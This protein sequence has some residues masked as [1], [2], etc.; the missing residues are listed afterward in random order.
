VDATHLGYMSGVGWIVQG[1]WEGARW[2]ARPHDTRRTVCGIYRYARGCHY[3][4]RAEASIYGT[5]GPPGWVIAGMPLIVGAV[6]AGH[7]GVI[8]MGTE[9][10]SLYEWEKLVCLPYGLLL[11][12]S[13]GVLIYINPIAGEILQNSEEITIRH[14][15]VYASQRPAQLKKLIQNVTTPASRPFLL[16]FDRQSARKPLFLMGIA[17]GQAL[18]PKGNGAI[19]ML[20]DPEMLFQPSI[21][22]LR[23]I[24]GFTPAECGV[25]ELLINGKGPSD[26]A[27]KLGISL[28]TA[29]SHIK[30]LLQKTGTSRQSE[31]VHLLLS[32]PGLPVGLGRLQ[33]RLPIPAAVGK[34]GASVAPSVALPD[35]RVHV[36]APAH[37]L[38]NCAVIPPS[39]KV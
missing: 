38:L 3:H 6:S 22:V 19:L 26:I 29:R 33:R 30:K 28:H 24:F 37:A 18:Y 7:G 20:G 31:F 11:V 34:A 25:A 2:I 17:A 35:W 21:E 13:E 36:D 12:N 15:E 27:A 10:E 32:C 5:G 9:E 39:A 14:G 4:R 1:R 8:P 16:R 23:S